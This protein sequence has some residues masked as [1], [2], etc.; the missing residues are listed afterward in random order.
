MNGGHTM[1]T[2]YYD[3]VNYKFIMYLDMDGVTASENYI[4]KIHDYFIKD[5]KEWKYRNFMQQY[6][7]QKEAVETLN[8]I[9]DVAPFTIILSTTRRFE[10]TPTEWNLIYRIN[11]VKAYIGGRTG[12]SDNHWRET[13]IEEYHF[14]DAGM[15]SFKDKPFIIIDDDCFDLQKYKDKLV[16][17]STKTGLTMYYYNEI[18]DKLRK[19]GVDV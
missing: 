17:V 16:H 5:D 15:F 12:K 6:C 2:Q 1:S 4:V 8:A 10:F 3:E 13:E 7:L 18:L 14:K 9:Y 11:G 19:Q